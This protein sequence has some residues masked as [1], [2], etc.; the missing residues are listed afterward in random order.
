METTI[1]ARSRNLGYGWSTTPDRDA[2]S[3]SI[4]PPSAPNASGGLATVER[5]AQ[6]HG[7]VCSGGVYSA[8]RLFVGGRPITGV[9]DPHRI[10]YAPDLT[11]AELGGPAIP[12]MVDIG[13]G[14]VM[15]RIGEIVDQ[16]REG[17]TLRVR[18][19]LALR[20]KG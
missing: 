1:S 19:G 15:P 12:R 18:L 17:R 2:P 4:V 11:D 7:R 10:Q 3:P 9:W 14:L 16:L 6:Y 5:E 8:A 20:E 13:P